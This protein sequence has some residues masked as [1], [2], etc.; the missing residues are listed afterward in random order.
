[1]LDHEICLPLTRLRDI[2]RFYFI[3]CVAYGLFLLF[4]YTRLMPDIV[5]SSD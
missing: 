3:E 4:R 2:T 1:M 5:L